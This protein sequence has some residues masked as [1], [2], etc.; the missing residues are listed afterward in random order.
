VQNT[1]NK[2]AKTAKGADVVVSSTR[3]SLLECHKFNAI[4][5]VIFIAKRLF[6]FK[7]NASL[8]SLSFSLSDSPFIRSLPTAN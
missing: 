6:N 7:P 4:F 5:I 1:R 8:F 2:M 3:V